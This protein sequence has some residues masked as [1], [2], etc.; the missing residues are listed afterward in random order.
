M[1][2]KMI[3][4]LI[5]A[6]LPILLLAG[7]SS[8]EDETMQGSIYKVYMVS[9]EETSISSYEVRTDIEKQNELVNFLLAQLTRVPSNPSFRAAIPD[10]VTSPEVSINEATITL[11]FSEDYY[12][13]STGGEILTRA[14]IVRTVSQIPGISY[15]SFQVAGNALVSATGMPVGIMKEDMFID[16][17]GKEINTE[18]KVTLTLYFANESGDGLIPVSR[19]LVYS[20]NIPIE[21]LVMEQLVGGV[22]EDEAATGA[23]PI[24]NGDTRVLSVTEK[25]GICYV[26]LD[27]GFLA[28]TLNVTPDVAIYS[29]VNSLVELPAVTKVQFSVDGETSILFRDVYPLNVLYE[30]NLELILPEEV[31]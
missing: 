4:F 31:Q 17:S 8:D 13:L 16:N 30:R 26:N 5:T 23:Y 2:R 11:D 15:C 25:D 21:K 10:D 12:N 14:A 24:I 28:Q 3:I 27:N 6:L 9:K 7:C 18:E 1:R 29:I 22:T 20:S 19:E